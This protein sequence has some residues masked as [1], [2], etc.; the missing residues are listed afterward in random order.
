MVVSIGERIPLN[1]QLCTMSEE[2]VDK[3][4][5]SEMANVKMVAMSARM[6]RAP[7]RLILTKIALS[8]TMMASV[9]MEYTISE[10]AMPAMYI[11]GPVGELTT[12]SCSLMSFLR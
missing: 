5:P 4:K 7:S 12:M 9:G 1:A 2:I 8:A 6:I 10:R 11:P 3:K